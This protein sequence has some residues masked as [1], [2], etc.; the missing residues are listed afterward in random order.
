LQRDRELAP[1]GSGV[2]FAGLAAG[3]GEQA[4][5]ETE[6]SSSQRECLS[7]TEKEKSL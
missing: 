3:C 4:A 2:P 6:D 5:Q 1:V 7:P